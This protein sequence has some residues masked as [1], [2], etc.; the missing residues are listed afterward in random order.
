[1]IGTA[2][3]V[4][5]LTGCC[6]F[7]F[8]NLT[9]IDETYDVANDEVDD[10]ACIVGRKSCCCCD[11]DVDAASNSSEYVPDERCKAWKREDL[12]TLIQFDLKLAALIS[13]L[14]IVFCLGSI[15]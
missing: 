8:V 13:L 2:V 6:L 11:V 7:S 1:M 15:L 10:V 4:L 9:R 12:V 14:S 5:G 3:C